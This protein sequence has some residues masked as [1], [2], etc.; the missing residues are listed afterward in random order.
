MK[1]EINLKGKIVQEQ[2][3]LITGETL[4][5][6]YLKFRWLFISN[7][8]LRLKYVYVFTKGKP[9]LKKIYFKFIYMDNYLIKLSWELFQISDFYST[10][11]FKLN[12]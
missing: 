8:S 5:F 9:E 7:V 1:V 2:A 3:L 6:I 10:Y 11:R 12:L 4:I